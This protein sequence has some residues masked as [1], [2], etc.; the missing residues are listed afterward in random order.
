MPDS[1]LDPKEDLVIEKLDA[2]GVRWGKKYVGGGVH[3]DN[4]LA[5]YKEVYGEANVEIEGIAAP[6]S[7][8]YRQGGEKLFRVWI[9]QEK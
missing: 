2:H 3:F 5:Q 7:S 6:E 9:K 1:C 8:C 4:W